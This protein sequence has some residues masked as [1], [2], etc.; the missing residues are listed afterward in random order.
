[1]YALVF[2]EKALK[3][4]MKL[5]PSIR[6]ELFPVLQERLLNPFVPS[7][8]LR[9]ELSGCYK[10]KLRKAGIRLVYYPD[11]ETLVVTVIA[12]G[13][14]DGEAVYRAASKEF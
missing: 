9:D 8:R 4:W 6:R 5:D 11:G 1:M 14:R 10:I 13:K 2:R 3:Q 12:V 7:A